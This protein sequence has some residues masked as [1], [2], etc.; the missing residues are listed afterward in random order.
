[1]KHYTKIVCVF[2]L[3]I[4]QHFEYGAAARHVSCAR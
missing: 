3:I 2:V 1:M 4:V